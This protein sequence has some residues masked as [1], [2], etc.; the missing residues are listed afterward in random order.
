MPPQ[1]REE[2]RQLVDGQ[3]V[4]RRPDVNDLRPAFDIA[5]A[6]MQTKRAS[7]V[8]MATLSNVIASGVRRMTPDI[9]LMPMFGSAARS[10]TRS[11][12]TVSSSSLLLT[13]TVA[14]TFSIRAGTSMPEVPTAPFPR[15]TCRR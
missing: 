5:H 3:L 2:P 9:P 13:P 10:E 8:R 6:A 7:S 4:R 1:P 14:S 11:M 12:S 15:T